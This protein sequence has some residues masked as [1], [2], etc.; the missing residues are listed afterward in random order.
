MD[1]LTPER[2]S[3][4]M[5]RIRS[6]STKAEVFVR[7]LLHRKGYRFRVSLKGLP[8][9]PDIVFTKRKRIIFV[10]GC[11][12]HQHPKKNCLDARLPKSRQ[13]YWIPKLTRNVERDAANNRK[14]RRLGWRILVLWECDV[15]GGR[16]IESKLVQFLGPVKTE[17]D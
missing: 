4:N 15:F 12:W 11:F 5:R 14:L 7:S 13:E 10:H 9:K 1:K 8:G 2:R 17:E 6:S 16:D 3:E